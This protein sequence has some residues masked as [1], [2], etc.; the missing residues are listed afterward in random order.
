[1]NDMANP[2]TIGRLGKPHGLKGE[3]R[4]LVEQDEFLDHLEEGTY[5]MV[6]GLPYKIRSARD[7]GG[8]VIALEG[9]PDRSAVEGLKG[10]ALALPW[11]EELEAISLQVDAMAEWIGFM[12]VDQ[13]TGK[14][15]GEIVDYIDMPGQTTVILERD[16]KEIYVPLHE[17]LIVDMDSERKVVVMDLP[18]GLED[19]NT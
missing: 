19:L 17:D 11:S 5:V 9:L 14:Q 15:F 8:W 12:V 2:I 4:V 3:V 10:A 18:E 13:H 6:K 16:G 1:M 7:A